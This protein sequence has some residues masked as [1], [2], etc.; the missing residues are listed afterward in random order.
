MLSASGSSALSVELLSS[1]KSLQVESG[2]AAAG[3]SGSRSGEFGHAPGH[4]SKEALNGLH[5]TNSISMQHA[6]SRAG[7]QVT[8]VLALLDSLLPVLVNGRDTLRTDWCNE[9]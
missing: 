6:T 5:D 4:A 9:H 3:P 2:N 8:P 1:V 7:T